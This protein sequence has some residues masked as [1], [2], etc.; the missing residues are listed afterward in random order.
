MVLDTNVLVSALITPGSLP[1]RLVQHW[2]AGDLTLVTSNWA[3]A[4]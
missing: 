1:D 3:F 4:K 2:E